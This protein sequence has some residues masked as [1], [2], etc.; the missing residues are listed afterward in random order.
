MVLP[1]PPGGAEELSGS[2]GL[3]AKGETHVAPAGATPGMAIDVTEHRTR[4][5]FERVVPGAAAV[6]AAVLTCPDQATGWAIDGGRD[7]VPPFSDRAGRP[8]P[9]GRP[10][11]GV[12]PREAEP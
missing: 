4:E 9:S 11:P 5:P 12:C 6:A 3:P 8:A 10:R 2:A 7:V 1:R